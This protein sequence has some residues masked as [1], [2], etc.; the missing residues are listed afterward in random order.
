MKYLFEEYIDEDLVFNLDE[1]H[2]VL[3]Q[4]DGNA[5]E[6]LI[7]SRVNYCS[8]ILDGSTHTIAKNS[9]RSSCKR[10]SQRVISRG[11]SAL[12]R[13]VLVESL[14]NRERLPPPG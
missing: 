14:G 7:Q 3:Y 10:G 5:L 4:N 1:N 13:A 12:G 2:F 6:I 11:F 8:A 9:G